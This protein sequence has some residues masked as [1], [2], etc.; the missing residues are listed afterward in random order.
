[1]TD[2]YYEMLADTSDAELGEKFSATDLVKS[3][4]SATMQHAAPMSALLVRA[5]AV[6]CPR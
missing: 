2:C 6:R 5:L 1:M 3:T 4:W